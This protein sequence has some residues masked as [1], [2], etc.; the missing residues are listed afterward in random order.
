MSFLSK[1]YA[2]YKAKITASDDYEFRYYKPSGGGRR[3]DG[4]RHQINPLVRSIVK[5]FFDAC[6]LKYWD[7]IGLATVSYRGVL[8]GAALFVKHDVNH[9]CV[10][11]VRIEEPHRR[12]GLATKLY[13]LIEQKAG[14]KLTPSDAQSDDAES[15]WRQP[16]RPFGK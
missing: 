10:E 2:K 14:I 4:N 9:N 13:Q 1:V 8:V 3:S 6:W 12:K 11:A 15:L 5:R 7:E 16:N